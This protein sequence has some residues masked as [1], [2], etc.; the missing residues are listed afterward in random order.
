MLD[1][2]G[3]VD[4][5]CQSVP[6]FDNRRYVWDN[7]ADFQ[8]QYKSNGVD[9]ERFENSKDG[10]LEGCHGCRLDEER[11]EISSRTIANLKIKE[12]KD[13]DNA[14]TSAVVNAG[15]IC[16][17]AC[18]MCG[19]GSSSK[20][21]SLAR[22]NP[23]PWMVPTKLIEHDDLTKSYVKKKVLTPDLKIISFAGGEP[24]MN[25]V[26]EEYIDT[27]LEKNIAEGIWFQFITNGTHRP[28]EKWFESLLKF[29]F[30]EL[31]ISIDGTFDNYEYIRT[32]SDWELVW[33]NLHY[34][35]DRLSVRKDTL[36][37]DIAYCLQAL[38][39][40]KWNHDAKFWTDWYENFLDPITNQISKQDVKEEIFRPSVIT[41]PPYTSLSVI[42]PKLA[43]KYD[44]ERWT[45]A[46]EYRYEDYKEFMKFNGF[47][48]RVK[49]TSLE[50]Q[51]PDFFDHS[52]YPFGKKYYNDGYN[53]NI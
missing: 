20:W 26:C 10:Y 23:S 16:N 22:H 30:V 28:S 50:A 48:D 38:N 42:H 46:H 44:I 52:I 24:L 4:V 3:K 7:V 18:R 41:Y 31:T 43:K 17:L 15:N 19:D 12:V 34:I 14:I 13:D 8:H 40:H 27:I 49:G 29:K 21:G 53:K 51:N 45:S 35:I 11:F 6:S 25:K 33:E 39:A 36:H 5:C 2:A 37:I 47:W 9:F 32:Y 1:P